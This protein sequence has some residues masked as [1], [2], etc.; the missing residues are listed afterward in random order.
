MRDL[1]KY[2]FLLLAECSYFLTM[3]NALS[4]CIHLQ[5]IHLLNFSTKRG[6]KSSFLPCE[7]TG[8]GYMLWGPCVWHRLRR[9]SRGFLGLCPSDPSR[10]SPWR[11]SKGCLP[12]LCI[13]KCIPC[14]FFYTFEKHSPRNQWVIWL[15]ST[16]FG[17]ILWG[18]NHT[19]CV[20]KPGN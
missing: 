8:G 12:L 16:F 20:Y 7:G 1:L 13:C 18:V 4:P 6:H 17:V 15:V 14:I 3:A 11:H 9:K 19:F 10:K 2:I 5:P